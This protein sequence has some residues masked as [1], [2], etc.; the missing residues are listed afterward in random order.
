[1]D[2][3]KTPIIYNYFLKN[4]KAITESTV[5]LILIIVII[6][7]SLALIFGMGNDFLSIFKP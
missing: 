2:K 1:M 4:K 6:F 3:M 7:I 5:K